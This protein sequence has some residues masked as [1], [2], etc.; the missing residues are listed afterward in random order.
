M[1]ALSLTCL[2][3]QHLAFGRRKDEPGRG[4][5]RQRPQ[6]PSLDSSP[7]NDLAGAGQG[8][9]LSRRSSLSHSGLFST[10]SYIPEGNSAVAGGSNASDNSG[11]A[12][13]SATDGNGGAAGGTGSTSTSASGGRNEQQLALITRDSNNGSTSQAGIVDSPVDSSPAARK[14]SP[15]PPGATSFSCVVDFRIPACP[16]GLPP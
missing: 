10:S 16:S 8:G 15:L 9:S 13:G 5:A 14:L 12:G 2:P 7:Q 11:G 6:S 1:S 4:T 3:P